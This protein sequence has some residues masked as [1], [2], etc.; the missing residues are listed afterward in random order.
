M[1]SQLIRRALDPLNSAGP[2]IGP[3]RVKILR[4]VFFFFYY[5]IFI[6]IIIIINLTMTRK[7]LISF[8]AVRLRRYISTYNVC[9]VE[10]F[11]T[12]RK[13]IPSYILSV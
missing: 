11:D 1:K 4:L 9:R 5:K 13:Q 3:C 2:L 7:P 6:I 10:C 12:D 8:S